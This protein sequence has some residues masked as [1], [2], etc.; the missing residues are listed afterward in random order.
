MSFLTS[1]TQ[2]VVLDESLELSLH[3]VADPS[4]WEAL[5]SPT[6]EG[7]TKYVLKVAWPEST[8]FSEI[9]ILEEAARMGEEGEIFRGHLPMLLC[10]LEL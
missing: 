9:K 3:D 10:L 5:T 1:A 8:R 7:T 6:L 2:D 4:D